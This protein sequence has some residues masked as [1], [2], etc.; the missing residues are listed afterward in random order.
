MKILYIILTSIAVVFAV[1]GISY[2]SLLWDGVLSQKQESIR[3]Q[4]VE[5]SKAYKD[6]MRK[7]LGRISIEYAKAD[8][9]GKAAIKSYVLST[10]A[11]EPIGDYP[12]NL[13]TFLYDMGL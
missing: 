12:A 10:Y 7:E 2:S 13:Q 9:A 11:A 1:I 6:G 3:T 5:Q 4:V 8:P